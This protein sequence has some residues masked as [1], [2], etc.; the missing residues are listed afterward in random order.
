MKR[1]RVAAYVVAAM[2]VL[3]IPGC[4]NP[5]SILVQEDVARALGDAGLVILYGS[6]PILPE[7]V[8]TIPDTPVITEETADVEFTIKNDGVKVLELTGELPVAFSTTGTEF[9]LLSSQPATSVS[10]G[11]SVRFTVRFAPITLGRKVASVT[12]ECNDPDIPSFVFL[13]EGYGSAPAATAVPTGLSATQGTDTSHIDLTWDPVSDATE[14]YIYRDTVD[15][16]PPPLSQHA[17]SAIAAWTDATATPG[18]LYY[19]WVRAFAPAPKGLSDYSGSQTGYIKLGTV[20]MISASEGT[21]DAHI[22]L[23]WGAT[24]G[25]STYELYRSASPTPPLA[26]YA[27]TVAGLAGTTED[28]AAPPAVRYYYWVRARASSSDSVG[29]WSPSSV[30]GYRE[31][32]PPTITGTTAGDNS[33]MLYWDA[34][35]NAAEYRITVYSDAA[36]TTKINAFLLSINPLSVSSSFTYKEVYTDVSLPSGE[37]NWYATMETRTFF[38]DD[39]WSDETAPYPVQALGG[40]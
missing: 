16:D 12:I 7:E 22:S 19:Y 1:Q 23:A 6:V 33:F 40:G 32:P 31:M 39:H 4:E 28:D 17:T 20:A 26:S 14:Y 9:Q 8:F 27:A 18:Q 25:A 5:V 24:T 3:L 36:G 38:P 10:P 2:L 29:D 30:N 13:I 35:E 37:F 34:V 15:A 21:S 11:E